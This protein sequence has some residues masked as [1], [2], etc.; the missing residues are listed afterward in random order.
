[1]GILKTIKRPLSYI[2]GKLIRL[3][4][5]FT[6]KEV[7]ASVGDI[8]LQRGEIDHCQFLLSSRMLDVKDFCEHN[9]KNFKYQNA[10]SQATFGNSHKEALGN[11]R[12]ASLIE[13][14]KEK[15][16][17][18]KST[19]LVDKEWRLNDGNH[20]MGTN[21]YF[22]INNIN[23]RMTKRCSNFGRDVDQYFKINVA[24][25]I[26]DKVMAGYKDI[27]EWLVATGN[28]FCCILKNE[29]N[30]TDIVSDMGFMADILC[31]RPLPMG[32]N[33][34]VLS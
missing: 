10:I 20:R 4:D 28:T 25:S 34:S 1:M 24:T 26:I 32:G 18:S 2:H 5:T 30:A 3:Y 7:E 33:Y 15:G 16:Y 23:V 11:A 8:I 19:I 31:V 29:S 22:G 13:S 9:D 6:T 17:D 27:L 12:F 21:L 14:Y